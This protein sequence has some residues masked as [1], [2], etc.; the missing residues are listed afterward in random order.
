MLG[1]L[2]GRLKEDNPDWH[3]D[4]LTSAR[5][6]RGEAREGLPRN[7]TWRG[8]HIRWLASSAVGRAGFAVGVLRHDLRWLLFK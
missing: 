2:V 7:E 6:Y 3:I 1:D 4:V 5:V 8:V